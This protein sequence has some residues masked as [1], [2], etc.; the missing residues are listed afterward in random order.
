MEVSEKLWLA[1]H[2]S[3]M[4]SSHFVGT[5]RWNPFQERGEYERLSFQEELHLCIL[6]LAR[7]LKTEILVDMEVQ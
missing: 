3:V 2:I 1:P 4:K 6:S 7:D 5:D